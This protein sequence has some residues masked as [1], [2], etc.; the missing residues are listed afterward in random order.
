MNKLY[1]TFLFVSTFCTLAF[2]QSDSAHL[3][4]IV[5]KLEKLATSYPTEKVYLH[6]NKPAY[7]IGDTIW[8]KGYLTVGPRHQPSALSGVLYVEL[9]DNKNKLVKLL[10]LKNN[11]GVFAGEFAIDGRLLPGDYH[12]RAYTNWM[13]NAGPDYFFNRDINIGNLKT[14]AI[15]VSSAFTITKKNNDKQVTTKLSY[16]DKFG[17]PYDNREVSYEVRADSILLHKGKGI[18]DDNGDLSFT[19]PGK[20]LTVQQVH[21]I[22]HIKLITGVMVDK[23]IPFNLQPDNSIDIQFFPE[24]GKLVNDVRSRVAFKAIG[25]NGLGADVMGTITDNDNVEVAEFASQ[26]AGM[27]VFALTPRAGKTYTAKI[28][29]ADNSI[30]TEKLPAASEKGFILGVNNAPADSTK[31]NIRIATNAA[32]LQ[33]KKNIS[34]YLVGQS[35]EVSYFTTAGKLDNTSFIISVPKNRF[36]S[37][38]A[39]FTLFS[40]T[41]EPMNERVVFIQNNDGLNLDLKTEKISYAPKEKVNIEVSVSNKDNKPVAGNFSLSVYNESDLN[42]NEDNETNI[43]SDILLTS[44]LKG[45]IEQPNYY[46][47]H[48]DNKAKADLDVLMLTQGYRRFEWKEIIADKYPPMSFKSEKML[49]LSGTLTTSS[50][51][52]AAKGKVGILSVGDNA[53]VNTIADDQGRFVFANIKLQDTTQKMFIQARIA[54]G[55][56][57]VYIK[58][59]ANNYPPIVGDNYPATSMQT[60]TPSFN[61]IIGNTAKSGNAVPKADTIAL[62]KTIKPDALEKS[63]KKIELTEVNVKGRRNKGTELAPWIIVSPTSANLNGPGHADMVFST[64]DFLDC[65][66]FFE[67]FISKVP[68]ITRTYLPNDSTVTV[69][70]TTYLPTEEIDYSI[71]GHKSFMMPP[72]IKYMLDGLLVKP[73]QV[74]NLD[75][76]LIASVEVLTSNTYLGAYGTTAPGGLIIITTKAGLEDPGTDY[77]AQTA[78]GVLTTKFKGY[79]T[80][81]EFYVPK[82]T[83]ANVNIPDKRTAVYWTPNVVTGANGNFKAEFFNSDSKGNYKVVLEGIDDNGNLGRAVYRYKV[84]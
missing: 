49:T 55:S 77:N 23:T 62:A 65:V 53:M 25:L 81:R 15:F 17:N 72:D 63:A 64:K 42:F 47:D 12:I 61:T 82:Y 35:A 4:A 66:D 70:G 28:T 51:K 5:S 73:D 58:L 33:E 41:N 40:S 7:N 75:A 76:M 57:D 24:G 50:G 43:L 18:T 3:T 31:L 30:I 46:F 6:L 19:F 20:T 16:T 8:L 9:I 84:E 21:I 48:S 60:A 52:P 39:Q 22:N 11:N 29:L 45:Y 44:D 36:P 32:T 10:Q 2:S 78:P 1:L 83:P 27:G 69:N 68:G 59:D 38:I 74:K 67:C 54:N 13:R 37:G 34:F 71:R 14:N 56:K 26:H 80:A 79:N